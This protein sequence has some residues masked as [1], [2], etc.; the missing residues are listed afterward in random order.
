MKIFRL[1]LLGILVLFSRGSFAQNN[2]MDLSVIPLIPDTVA[3]AGMVD[4]SF[5]IK[6]QQPQNMQS[7]VI[8]LGAQQNDGS[9]Y[10]DSVQIVPD[11]MGYATLYN[12]QKSS[13]ENYQTRWILRLSELQWSQYSYI[14]IFGRMSNATETNRLFW[15][16]AS[17]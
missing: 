15:Q 11:N 17:Q 10:T 8:L 2:I 13:I 12:N 9:I 7:I 1:L 3:P 6:V 4:I 5:E 16:K 14:T